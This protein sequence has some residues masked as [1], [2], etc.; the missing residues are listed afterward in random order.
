MM[1]RLYIV[2]ALLFIALLS[3][4]FETHAGLFDFWK[5]Y[6]G[7]EATQKED[8]SQAEQAFRE[9]IASDPLPEDYYNLGVT[10]YKQEKFAEAKENFM[11]ALN[12]EDPQIQQQA[13][14]NL[15]NT[16][17]R[18]KDLNGAIN[19]YAKALEIN[20]QDGEAARNLEF[21]RRQMTSQSQNQDQNQS[22]NSKGEGQKQ[23]Q[24]SGSQKEG[25]QASKQ[26]SQGNN[27]NQ[28]QNSQNE[29]SQQ[30]GKNSDSQN[31]DSKGKSGQDQS[32]QAKN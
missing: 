19:A 8:Y 31:Q 2:V 21:V 29:N 3:I 25:S 26:D 22:Q 28:G 12:S 10:Q 5:D 4:S 23:E 18:L 9:K 14:Y 17:Y 13:Y 15:G 16:L 6:R 32:Q 27:Q 30:N 1:K 24:G 11:A 7:R 20:P